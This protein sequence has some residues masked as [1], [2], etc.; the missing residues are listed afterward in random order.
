M[1]GGFVEFLC[2]CE[3]S[4]R[5]TLD[6]SFRWWSLMLYL[7]NLSRRPHN[8]FLPLG[9]SP[10]HL[11]QDWERSSSFLKSWF[12]PVVIRYKSSSVM[13]VIKYLVQVHRHRL[14]PCNTPSECR[15]QWCNTR[16]SSHCRGYGS[17]CCPGL[18]QI[19]KI[20]KL[21]FYILATWGQK[22]S[23]TSCQTRTALMIYSCVAAIF[24]SSH[25]LLTWRNLV[26]LLLAGVVVGAAAVF[27]W[28]LNRPALA[29]FSWLRYSDCASVCDAFPGGTGQLWEDGGGLW[30]WGLGRRQTVV[31]VSFKHK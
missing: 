7:G 23:T 22:N 11:Q 24:V 12:H 10:A 3:V 14:A 29:C 28:R 18:W 20:S 16:A 9:E 21:S 8:S 2:G 27:L 25:V 17:S 4:W 15:G 30:C 6:I 26:M 31:G 13:F 19:N 5:S 1:W